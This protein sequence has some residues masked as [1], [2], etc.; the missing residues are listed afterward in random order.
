MS[1]EA[2]KGWGDW[3]HKWNLFMTHLNLGYGLAFSWETWCPLPEWGDGSPSSLRISP[4][5]TTEVL[6]PPGPTATGWGMTTPW[7]STL[8]SK[9]PLSAFRMMSSSP[10]LL[11]GS[12]KEWPL[13]LTEPAGDG[14]APAWLWGRTGAGTAQD[15]R[16]GTVLAA[17]PPQRRLIPWEC[18][19]SCVKSGTHWCESCSMVFF[20]F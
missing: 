14:T 4:L 5:V 19:L 15:I 2:E 20:S 16:P 12:A 11:A 8:S 10:R 7:S 3:A 13:E 17:Q 1:E 9:L 6:A 18:V